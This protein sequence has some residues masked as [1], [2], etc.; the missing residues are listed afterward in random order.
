MKHFK[1][2][3]RENPWGKY[4]PKYSPGELIHVNGKFRCWECERIG[5]LAEGY[6]RHCGEP[7]P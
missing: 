3:T 4:G 1:P 7:S 5:D 6:C 2:E